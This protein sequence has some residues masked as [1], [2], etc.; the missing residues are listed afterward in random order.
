MSTPV[1]AVDDYFSGVQDTILDGNVS[2]N[3]TPSSGSGLVWALVNTPS[4]GQV[5]DFNADGTF[6]YQ[7]SMGY[8]GTD[9]FTYSLTDTSQSVTEYA[10]VNLEI[11][12][13]V[14]AVD[15][16][17]TV[18]EGQ[19]FDG[20]VSTNDIAP[21]IN[22]AQWEITPSTGPYHGSISLD[23]SSGGF[24]YIPNPGFVGDD[25]F[26]Y[27]LTNVNTSQSSSATVTLHVVSSGYPSIKAWYNGRQVLLGVIPNALVFDGYSFVRPQDAKFVAIVEV[28]T[29]G[30]ETVPPPWP[31]TQTLEQ[32]SLTWTNVWLCGVIAI[33]QTPI[34]DIDIVAVTDPNN[35]A[36]VCG[37]SCL[38]N[39]LQY[40]T[41]TDV[42]A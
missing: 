28:V 32:A 27:T 11:I 4:H 21:G 36:C 17:F 24:I 37:I 40:V 20:D 3:D 19:E 26:G 9:S 25:T 29:V 34:S 5:L 6:S 38:G 22:I 13:A 18:T 30:P 8:Y 31:E 12:Q 16:V 35:G 1:I 10:T 23:A 33:D 41:V 7:P 15:D 39:D 14:V 2:T 42:T